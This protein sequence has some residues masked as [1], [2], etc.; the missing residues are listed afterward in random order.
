MGQLLIVAGKTANKLPKIDKNR[1][2][3]YYTAQI[4]RWQ[5]AQT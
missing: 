4:E 3:G 5:V 2:V 1:I